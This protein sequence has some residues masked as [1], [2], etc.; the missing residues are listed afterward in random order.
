M[1]LP[2]CEREKIGKSRPKIVVQVVEYAKMT[3]SQ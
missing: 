2:R 1:K 3:I